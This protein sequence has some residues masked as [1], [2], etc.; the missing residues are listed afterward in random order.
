MRTFSVSRD[1]F[2]VVPTLTCVLKQQQLAALPLP[3]ILLSDLVLALSQGRTECLGIVSRSAALAASVGLVWLS[4]AEHKR[5]IRPS[6]LIVLYLLLTIVFDTFALTYPGFSNVRSGGRNHALLVAEVASRAAMLLLES[7]D[8][9][10]ILRSEYGRASPEETAGL[11]SSVL[12]WW[13]NGLLS[14]GNRSILR[15]SHLPP[16]DS[17]LEAEGL[18]RKILETWENRCKFDLV[19]LSL[20]TQ[21]PLEF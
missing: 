14:R 2:L 8:K 21:E 19:A 11:I 5:S 10:S 7:Q 17:G 6:N 1:A 20:R 13:L 3:A 9:T 15:G 18:R 12:F 16:L 4:I